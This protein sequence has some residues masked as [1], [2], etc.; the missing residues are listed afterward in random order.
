M[1]NGINRIARAELETIVT[2]KSL[3]LHTLTVDKGAVLAAFVHHVELAAL[4]DD[5]GVVARDPWVSN[6]Q[7]FFHL[8]TDGEWAVVEIERALLGPL[9][10]NQAGKDAGAEAGNGSDDGLGRHGAE[11]RA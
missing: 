7:V 4:G 6:D 1:E 3:P 10:E 2:L 9:Y 8:A 11:S 5:E